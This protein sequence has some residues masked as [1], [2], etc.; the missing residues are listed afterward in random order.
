MS[1]VPELPDIPE[2]P[3]NNATVTVD[4]CRAAD[5][6]LMSGMGQRAAR[7]RYSQNQVEQPVASAWGVESTCSRGG[8][9][10]REGIQTR[11][12]LSS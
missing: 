11:N 8:T 6:R 7:K 5:E 2:K 1:R 10:G 4:G 3:E 12:K 9:T